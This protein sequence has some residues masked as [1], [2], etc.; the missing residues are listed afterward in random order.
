MIVK[1]II[2][3]K[4]GKEI[5]NLTYYNKLKF[6]LRYWRGGSMGGREDD[7]N[8]DIDIC[9][10]CAGSLSLLLKRWTCENDC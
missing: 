6:T 2:C 7:E 5:T 9:G 10:E 1:K 3:D 4:C 8:F